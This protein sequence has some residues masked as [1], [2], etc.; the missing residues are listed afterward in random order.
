MPMHEGLILVV[1]DNDS[2][3]FA[4]TQVVSRAGFEV[5]EAETGQTALEMLRLHPVD[6]V[7]L[8][9]NLPDINGLDV[10][11]KV[12]ADPTLATV[13]VLHVSATAVTD[14]DRV[15]GLS[16]GADGYLT[17]P[18]NPQVTVATLKALMRVRRAEQERRAAHERE[19]QARAAA[20]RANET[21]DRFLATLSHELRTP[22]NAM[23]GWLALLKDGRLD[24]ERQQRAI[25]A[26]ER[27]ANQQWRLVSEL[28]DAASIRQGRIRL[29]IA[30]VDLAAVATAAIEQVRPEATRR[31]I[32]LIIEA[33]MAAVEGDEARLQQVIAN[34]LNNAIQFTPVGGVVK[35][36]IGCD[37]GAATVDVID[38]GIGI[39][40]HF[41]PYVFEEFRQ[42]E[43]SG[44]EHRGLGLGLAIARAIVELHGGRISAHSAG[45]GRGATFRVRLPRRQQASASAAS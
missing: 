33:E 43:G 25:E 18:Q 5:V 26:I 36:A 22:L 23:I 3:R 19:R 8:D 1:D 41:L 44:N 9:V 42:A 20:E 32:D 13:Q 38:S 15:R 17:E 10:C 2:S 7:L 40:P 4:K 30:A 31:Q 34:L 24:A 39:E 29:E 21:K 16:G 14:V 6:I 37:G 45:L 27:S 12:K 28:L 35:L 11:R